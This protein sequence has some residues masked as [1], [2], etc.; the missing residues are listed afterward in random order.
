MKSPVGRNPQ[1]EMY[2]Q[3]KILM[4]Y[5]N[6]AGYLLEDR[7]LLDP[8]FDKSQVRDYINGQ[9]QVP[10]EIRKGV[11]DHLVNGEPVFR[12][13]SAKRFRI[14]QLRKDTPFSMRFI[15]L[16]ERK[17]RGYGMPQQ[18]EYEM[19]YEE[20]TE[21]FHL[22]AIWESFGKKVPKDFHGHALSISDVVELADEENR[23]F[24]YVDPAGYTEIVFTSDE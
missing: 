11:Y 16:A 13:D 9:L 14:H 4:Y 22:E 21:I 18:R 8:L 3:N 12:K 7:I 20:E 15:S 24:F 17:R 6:P 23:R 1:K 2:I 19:V 10:I 5:G